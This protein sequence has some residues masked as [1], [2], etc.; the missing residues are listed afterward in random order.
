[1]TISRESILS[2]IDALRAK[3]TEN[4]C[5]EAEALAAIAAVERLMNTYNIG[6]NEADLKDDRAILVEVPAEPMELFNCLHAI[7]QLTSTRIFRRRRV[8]VEDPVF[9]IVGLP[10]D[11]DFASFLLETI[12]RAMMSGTVSFTLDNLLEG[13]VPRNKAFAKSEEQSFRVG[14]AERIHHRIMEM[15]RAR[16][17]QKTGSGRDLVVVKSAIADQGLRAFG[18]SL[19]SGTLVNS[20][21]HSAMSKGA[22]YGSSIGLGR[23]V[24]G[25]SNAP[26]LLK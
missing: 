20:S 16:T 13:N 4:G 17:P 14:V 5:T 19:S 25:S 8:G 6:L 22:A 7:A 12:G 23:P 9:G 24:S 15:V 3:T 21:N 1:M 2:K 11:V 26:K 18:I 10:S